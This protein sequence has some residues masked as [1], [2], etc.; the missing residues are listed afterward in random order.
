MQKQHFL[1]HLSHKE[2]TEIKQMLLVQTYGN[3]SKTRNNYMSLSIFF[4]C[5]LN[6]LKA[7]LIISEPLQRNHSICYHLTA[8]EGRLT[9]EQSISSI[10]AASTILGLFNVILLEK[11]NGFW[12]PLEFCTMET[13]QAQLY[14]STNMYG[15]KTWGHRTTI[16][17]LIKL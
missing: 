1:L 15:K 3:I 13:R 8:I 17:G 5:T 9:N 10:G 11:D 12:A 2:P 6:L 14:K 4:Y 16:T 7:S